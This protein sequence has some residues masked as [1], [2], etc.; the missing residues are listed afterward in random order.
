[1]DS[2][3]QEKISH[4]LLDLISA[5]ESNKYD[6]YERIPKRYR[7][8]KYVVYEVNTKAKNVDR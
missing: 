5:K 4:L 1:M 2:V 3:Y 7:K 6:L 8:L